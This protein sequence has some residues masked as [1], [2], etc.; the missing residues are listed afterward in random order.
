[1]EKESTEK[2]KNTSEEDLPGKFETENNSPWENY[3]EYQ[4]TTTKR[5]RITCLI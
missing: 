3:F 1:M 2:V 5:E 4:K